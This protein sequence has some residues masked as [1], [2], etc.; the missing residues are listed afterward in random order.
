M[1]TLP[2]ASSARLSDLELAAWTGFLRA[3]STVT[4]RLDRELEAECDLSLAEYDV[5]VTLAR[6]PGRRLRMTDL[7]DAVL[8]SR[9]GLTR[10]VDRLE[11]AGLVARHPCASDA[12]VSYVGLA[13]EGMTLLR[14]AS[15]VHLRGVRRQVTDK[16]TEAQQQAL[17]D[18]TTLLLAE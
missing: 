6:A 2:P 14:R 5:L 7:A 13:P 3:H 15:V 10:L 18:L 4:R 9:S 1:A 17:R 8:L 11:S 12:R 16:L